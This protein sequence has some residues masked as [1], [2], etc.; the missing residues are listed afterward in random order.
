MARP[1]VF[2]SST[3]YDLRY[4]RADLDRFIREVGYE[5]VQHE[6]GHV[7]Y[8][9]SEKLE[10]YC[11]K[12]I[13]Q[14]DIVVNIVG[15]RFGSESYEEA[16]SVSQMELKTAVKL[17]KQCYIFVDSAVYAEYRMY[18]KN[19]TLDGIQYVAADDKRIFAF[20][21]EMEALP[22]NNQIIEFRH[23]DEIIGHLREQ[24]AGLFQRFLQEQAQLPDRR[25]ADDLQ[26]ALKTINQLVTFLTEERRQQGSTI[27]DILLTNHPMFAQLRALTKTPYPVY[28]PTRNDLN[29]WLDARGYKKV[30][31]DNWDEPDHAEWIRT[32]PGGKKFLLRINPCVLDGDRIHVYTGTEW[33]SEWITLGEYKPRTESFEDFPTDL[34]DDDL[35][36]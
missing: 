28:L 17:N 29:A 32:A 21:E 18:L 26:N 15:G 3:F 6:R 30:D 14:V 24:W 25:T 8:G 16:Y 20:V 4:V 34:N 13:S 11:Y 10:K 1:R 12:E 19:K 36:F 5:S 23:A 9:S 33:K 31:E 22:R 27:S 35:P 7:P 2:I